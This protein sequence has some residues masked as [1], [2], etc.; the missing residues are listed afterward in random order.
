MTK[1][2]KLQLIG[3][4]VLFLVIAAKELATCALAWY[5][6]SATAW[7]LN[8]KLFG[9]FQRSHYML[10]D[11]FSIPYFQ[12]LFV[13]IPILLLACIGVGLRRRFP[14]ALASNLSFTY[15][16][17]LA[18]AWRAVETPSLQAASLT[19]LGYSS[20]L[21]LSAFSLSSGPHMYVLTAL[22]IPSL[23]SFAA[24][25]VVYLHAVRKT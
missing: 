15:A 3:P 5:P 14:I 21:N 19:E 10:S 17:F 16:F 1:L 4:L 20:M 2:A 11:H 6:S 7:Y 12:L 22:F 25:H 24:S 23:L 8:L 13:A 18:Y 9:V